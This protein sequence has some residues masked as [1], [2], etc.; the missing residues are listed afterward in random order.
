LG[1]LLRF[2]LA[3][4]EDE[5]LRSLTL[6]LTQHHRSFISPWDDQELLFATEAPEV[7]FQ[8]RYKSD[9][10]LLT[11]GL[12][13]AGE[14]ERFF[15][16][17][18]FFLDERDYLS[19]LF[20]QEV[21]VEEDRR[22][23]FVM[24]PVSSLQVNH[25]LFRARPEELQSVQE[26]LE[27]SF[28][29]FDA[30][31]EAALA[32][33][34]ASPAEFDAGRLDPFPGRRTPRGRWINRPVLFRSTRSS[35]TFQLKK[36]LGALAAHERLLAGATDTALGYLTAPGRMRR[37]DGE[38]ERRGIV[39]VLPLNEQQERAVRAGLTMPFTVVTGPPGTGK[40]QVVVDILASCAVAGRAVLFASKNN[41]AVD[42]VHQRLREILGEGEDWVLRLGNRERVDA[43]RTEM[44]DRLAALAATG[45]EGSAGAGAVGSAMSA[46]ENDIALAQ[47]EL[48]RVRACSRS[49]LEAEARRRRIQ[50]VLPKHWVTVSALGEIQPP[51]MPLDRLRERRDEAQALAGERP[52]GFWLGLRRLVLGRC[53]VQGLIREIQAAAG[54]FPPQVGEDVL[55]RVRSATGYPSL[56]LA[57]ADLVSFGEWA[58]ATKEVGD[59]ERRL[60]QMPPTSAIARRI[61]A[62]KEKKAELSR[63]YLRQAWRRR[64]AGSM[65]VV[66]HELGN[67]FTLG[68]RQW[69]TQGNREWL[70]VLDQFTESIQKLGRILPVWIVTNL[71]ARRSMPLKP[72]IFDL[73]I[74]D[75]ASQCDIASA[76]PLLY[77]ARRAV[78]IGDPRQLRH[79]SAIRPEREAELAKEAG[80]ADL[81]AGWSYAV[82]SLYDAAEGAVLQVG[83]EPVFLAEHYRSHPAVVEFSNQTFYAGRLVVRTALKVLAAKL[84]GQPLGVFWHDIRGD[85]PGSARSA[86]NEVEARAVVELLERWYREGLLTRRQ[87][88]AELSFGVVTPF[89]LQMEKIEQMIQARPWWEAVRGRLTVGTAHRFQGDECDVMV[90]S[91]VVAEGLSVRMSRWVAQTDQLLNVAITRARGVLHVVGDLAACRGAGGYLAEFADYVA[92]GGGG[93][94]TTAPFESPA[95]ER[96]AELLTESGLWYRPQFE[97]GRHRLDFLVVSPLGTRYDLEVDGRA[98]CTPEQIHADQVR[99]S[100]MEA[101]GY[102]VVRVAA[103]DVFNRE[104][105]VVRLLARLP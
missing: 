65:G 20:V 9:H 42:V 1:R 51:A 61:D 104:D 57:L 10:A 71:S 31:L 64:V 50:A 16:G 22:G 7:R 21:E 28:G 88:R 3:C 83:R 80:V 18:P 14:A 67:Y 100:F 32:Y 66:R 38:A 76:I 5:D 87:G 105:A 13:Q 25:H 93:S 91:P 34:G 19:P 69:R 92:Q 15:Y 74:I 39:A 68:E 40:S 37:A 96:M 62:L 4:I 89:R 58:A 99:D 59:A 78:V 79:I 70:A 60:A 94:A 24:R 72:A 29:S 11:R 41:K 54:L 35:Y 6:K 97:E 101:R 17:Y 23:G 85:V 30:R 12:A 27:G 46:V 82:R 90:F 81:L 52:L 33:L 98:H 53:L 44:F 45:S 95:E 63:E 48:E 55:A 102:R 8:V 36:E 84:D 2:Y 47:A 103:R 26:E 73:V 77:R 75:E 49:L 43:C 86:W 56:A